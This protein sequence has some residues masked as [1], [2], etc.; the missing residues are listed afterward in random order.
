MELETRP[1][2]FHVEQSHILFLKKEGIKE[3]GKFKNY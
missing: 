2:L 1:K 3:K